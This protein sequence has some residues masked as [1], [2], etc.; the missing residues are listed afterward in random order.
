[1]QILKL[2]LSR[3]FREPVDKAQFFFVPG[4]NFYWHEACSV[5]ARKLYRRNLVE[6]EYVYHASDRQSP[7]FA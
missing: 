4:S 7:A 1:M 2:V 5:I 6:S 3:G